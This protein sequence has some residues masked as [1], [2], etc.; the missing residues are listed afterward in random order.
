MGLFRVTADGEATRDQVLYLKIVKT[1]K[2]CTLTEY[3]S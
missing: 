3:T 2:L 1:W